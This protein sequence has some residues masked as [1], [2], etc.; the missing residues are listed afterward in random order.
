MRELVHA[1]RS[2]LL[3][4]WDEVGCECEF[5][6]KSRPSRFGGFGVGEWEGV[7]LLRWLF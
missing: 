1:P 7:V 5:P 6:V 2:W 4:W 3:L